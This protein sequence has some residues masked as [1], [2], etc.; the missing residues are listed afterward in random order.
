MK[1]SNNQTKDY[2]IDSTESY[3]LK[4]YYVFSIINFDLKY[5]TMYIVNI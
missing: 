1:L 3:N 4:E 5:T 2:E